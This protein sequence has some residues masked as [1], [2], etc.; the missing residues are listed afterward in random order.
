[1]A[2]SSVAKSSVN[3]NPR[4]RRKVSP[5]PLSADESI[6]LRGE[7]A[8]LSELQQQQIVQIM[9][10]NKETLTTDDNGYTE[11]DLGS[12]SAKTVRQIQ[13]YIKTVRA[14]AQT[15]GMTANHNESDSTKKSPT[16]NKRAREQPQN[17]QGRTINLSDSSSS[18]DG[19]S[20]SSSGSSSTDSDSD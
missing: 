8:K 17:L 5:S 4:R 12:C 13:D 16:K 11:I 19:D 7:V 9:L 10:D 3:P 18:D 6:A 2:Q 20:S 15:I 1:M 14:D